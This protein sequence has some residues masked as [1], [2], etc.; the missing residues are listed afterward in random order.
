MFP[1][2]S[3]CDAVLPLHVIDVSEKHFVSMLT[4]K[5]KQTALAFSA[6]DW[7]CMFILNIGNHLQEK[8]LSQL[9]RPKYEKQ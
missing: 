2:D 1:S 9:W 3:S 4:Y 8:T 6:E 5:I 7:D